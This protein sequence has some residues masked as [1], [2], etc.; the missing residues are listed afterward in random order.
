MTDSGRVVVVGAGLAG[1]RTTEQLRARGFVGPITLIGT[2]SRPPYDRPPLS[3][4]ALTE[5]DL[6]P[7]LKADF[8][9]LG[10]DF[11]PEEAAT[12]LGDEAAVVT[13]RGTYPFD[14]L[15]LATGAL[16]VALPG[17]GR[18]RFL[19][20]YDDALALRDL[21]RPGLR[22]AIVGAGVGSAP[23]TGHRRG[24][25]RQPGHG[26]R[27]RSHAA[28]RGDRSPARSP[29]R[30]LVRRRRRGPAGSPGAGRGRAARRARPGRERVDCGRRD[31]HRGRGAA[32]DQVAQGFRRPAGERRGRG[33]PPCA[34]RGLAFTR[35]GT[36]PRSSRGGSGGGCGSSTGTWPCTRPRWSR[37]TCSA[38]TR[39]TTRC[40]TSGPSSSAG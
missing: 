23:R 18:Q 5:R 11:R 17:E 6:D 40:C 21:L 2:E 3:K 27:S 33:R 37:P 34:L 32:C 28:R 9:T 4:K 24:R 14:H 1:L 25:A 15:V 30:S 16:P 7:S 13:T 31:R 19:R 38:A 22:L 39:R 8:G 35:W 29:D 20:T 10:V 12:G 26:G 36:V